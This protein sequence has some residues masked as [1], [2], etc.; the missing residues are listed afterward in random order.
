VR[1][2]IRRTW[3]HVFVGQGWF[4]RALL[5][6]SFGV[7]QV[8]ASCCLLQLMWQPLL[9]SGMPQTTLIIHSTLCSALERHGV[10]RHQ[11]F[12]ILIRV[13]ASPGLGIIPLTRWV[14]AGSAL[15]LYGLVALG[16]RPFR[17]GAGAKFN[18]VMTVPGISRTP[19]VTA[20]SVIIHRL[21]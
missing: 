19:W 14:N 12:S 7:D 9:P 8:T 5:G 20:E 16:S 21:W 1:A 10:E 18:C 17:C 15:L 6:Y 4:Y 3:H 13:N 11:A 2:M